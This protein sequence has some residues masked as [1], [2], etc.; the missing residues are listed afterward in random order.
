MRYCEKCGNKLNVNEQNCSRCGLENPYYEQK[1][2]SVEEE[3][4]AEVV[5]LYKE[6]PALSTL[7]VVCAFLHPLIGLI[8][9]IVGL[10]CSQEDK[11]KRRC[12]FGL[13]ISICLLL[14]FILYFI[15]KNIRLF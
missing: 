15:F 6:S 9:S 11:F 8:L 14:G 13:I 12:E 2:D 1:N 10:S 4:S 3:K 5:I 7:A